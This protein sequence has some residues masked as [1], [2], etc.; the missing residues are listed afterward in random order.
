VGTVIDPN[1]TD[2]LRVTVVATGLQN[3]IGSRASI[4]NHDIPTK[5][6]VDNTVRKSGQPD[7]SRL[8]KPTILR[9]HAATGSV[10]VRNKN[11]AVQMDDGELE[12]L[13]IPAFLRRQAD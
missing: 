4:H 9:N 1:I 2:E 6:V 7:Y 8:D 12:Y 13:D 5:V 10:S 11:P 3:P